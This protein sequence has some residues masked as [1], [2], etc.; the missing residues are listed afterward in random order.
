MLAM[1]YFSSALDTINHSSLV[2]RLHGSFGFTDSAL[3]WF[4][5]YLT[6]RIQYVSSFNCCSD[7]AP[8]HSGVP[9]GSVLEPMLFSMYIKPL[10]TIIDSH[11][12]TQQLFADDFPLCTSPHPDKASTLLHYVQS[13]I[14]DINAL[15]NAIILR[16]DGMTELIL[17][18]SKKLRISIIYLPQSLLVLLKLLLDF[19]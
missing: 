12:I 8:M 17:T 18:T 7:F 14:S 3:R 5:S 6:D 10:S 1:L 2:H 19:L 13:C 9:Q 15:A 16:Y 4:S 11:S